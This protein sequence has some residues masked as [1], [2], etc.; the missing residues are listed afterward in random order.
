MEPH[1]TDISYISGG[2][3]FNYRVCAVIL[4]DGKILAMRD[5]RSP[6]YYLP[7]G[8]VKLGETAEE[9]VLREVSEELSVEASIVRPLWLCQSFFNEDVDKLDYHELCL[10]FLIDVSRTDLIGRG[11]RF[12]LHEGRHTHYFEWLGFSRLKDEYFYPLF[13]KKEIFGLPENLTLITARE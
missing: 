9:A 4:S 7:G 3:K 1:G 10:Y 6:Y 2:N 8:R 11:E 13:I 12:T 5:E